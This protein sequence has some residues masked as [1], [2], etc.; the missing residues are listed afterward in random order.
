MSDIALFQCA[1]ARSSASQSNGA[2][3]QLPFPLTLPSSPF[4]LLRL[5]AIDLIQHSLHRRLSLVS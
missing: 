1:V 5:A 4:I 3:Q 2:T